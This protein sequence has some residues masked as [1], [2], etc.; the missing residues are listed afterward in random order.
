MYW[1]DGDGLAG[2]GK[3]AWW[4]DNGIGYIHVNVF[5]K[6]N[7]ISQNR[8]TVSFTE[9]ILMSQDGDELGGMVVGL[10]GW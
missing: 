9:N 2:G 3:W 10:L 4:D 1:W 6:R 8:D 7:N 5:C